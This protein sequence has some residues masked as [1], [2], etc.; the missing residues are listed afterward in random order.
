MAGSDKRMNTITNNLDFFLFL[1]GLVIASAGYYIGRTITADQFGKEIEA[2]F[3]EIE[4]LREVVYQLS[5]S[6]KRSS[7]NHPAG[8]QLR[9]VRE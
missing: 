3:H 8:S 9:L 5:I 4:A 6:Q 2:H 1:T 7:A